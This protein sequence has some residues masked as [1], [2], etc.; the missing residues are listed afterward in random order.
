MDQPRD[1]LL[2]TI[3]MDN[4][5]LPC[6]AT[7]SVRRLLSGHP[8]HYQPLLDAGLTS[9]KRKPGRQVKLIPGVLGADDADA[10][11]ILREFPNVE[12]PIAMTESESLRHYG[13]HCRQRRVRDGGA[14]TPEETPHQ[15]WAIAAVLIV[16]AICFTAF[17]IV[18]MINF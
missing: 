15:T 2:E 17:L 13:P 12:H 16:G 1:F 6:R 11:I 8:D 18:G 9:I 3:Q 4:A 14:E 7:A 5:G 10:N